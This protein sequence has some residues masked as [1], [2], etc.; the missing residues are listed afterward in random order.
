MLCDHIINNKKHNNKIE[1]EMQQ[2][3]E[4]ETYIVKDVFKKRKKIQ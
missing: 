1:K 2:V 3:D 4:L